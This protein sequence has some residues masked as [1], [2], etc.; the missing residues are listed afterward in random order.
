MMSA[1]DDGGDD[2]CTCMA[3]LMREGEDKRP[4]TMPRY[5]V[6]DCGHSAAW[7]ERLTGRCT[8]QGYRRRR[9]QT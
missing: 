7:H 2:E 3:Y 4:A 1:A 5:R 8:F 9:R 6:C